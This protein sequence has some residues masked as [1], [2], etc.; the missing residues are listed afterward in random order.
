MTVLVTLEHRLTPRNEAFGTSTSP[1]NTLDITPVQSTLLLPLI[2]EQDE[3]GRW[4]GKVKFQYVYPFFSRLR[5]GHL[6]IKDLE[7]P[8][9]SL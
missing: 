8:Y 4:H 9:T 6:L 2:P 1:S 5:I 3:S 7:T